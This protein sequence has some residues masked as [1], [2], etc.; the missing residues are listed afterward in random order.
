MRVDPATLLDLSILDPGEESASLFTLI[1][2]TRTDAGRAELRR[3]MRQL[4]AL[5]ETQERQRAVRRLSETLSDIR[6]IVDDARP[7]D[8]ERYLSLRWQ[9]LTRRGRWGQWFERLVLRL[10]YVDAIRDI[11]QGM[12]S[13]ERLLR[14]SSRFSESCDRKSGVLSRLA[15]EVDAI[16]ATDELRELNRSSRL[17]HLKAL[18]QADRLAR[19]PARDRIRR[20]VG[21]IAELDAMQSLAAATMDLQWCFPDLTSEAR[22]LEF[23]ALRHP[24]LPGATV[25]DILVSDSQRV[26]AITGP[27]MA[28]KSTL[29]K[30]V[31]SAVYLAHLGC[32]VPATRAVV[33]LFDAM[34]ASLVVR[35]SVSSGRSFYLS[36]V[37][38]IRDLVAVLA[39]HQRVFAVFDEPFKG[40]NIN[41][42]SD[43]MSLLLRGLCAQNES[44][45]VLTTHLST[46]VES[47][48]ADVHLAATFLGAQLGGDGPV[49]DYQ[50]RQG[51]S[52]Q[53]LGMV[54]LERE[55]VAPALVAAIERKNQH[56]PA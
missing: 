32:G 21:I 8:A 37:R 14:A 34:L 18:L 28:G 45:V 41:D 27:N 15:T 5:S 24:C 56:R 36:E 13:I 35:D 54:L 40:T 43:A 16:L 7:D 3:R 26:M 50:L 23:R 12:Q 46:V 20:L 33:P 44:L 4:P 49:F 17:D 39:E 48:G 10:V 11:R 47:M 22:T 25:N 30:A 2:R 9:A 19:G 38:R 29:L 52:S 1:D 6:Q 51:I 55:G 53:R 42:A 31:G